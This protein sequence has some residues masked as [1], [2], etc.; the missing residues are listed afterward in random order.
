MH[1]PQYPRRRNR[2][3]VAELAE[4]FDLSHPL[5][6]DHDRALFEALGAVYWP[7]F[8]LVDK[9]GHVRMLE[10]GEKQAGTPAA[11]RF[12]QQLRALLAES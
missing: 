9:R 2:A 4:R 11:E 6:I 5:Y 3:A 12:E 10:L 7:T 8:V 1:S